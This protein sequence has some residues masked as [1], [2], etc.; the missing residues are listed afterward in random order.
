M[1]RT[2]STVTAIAVALVLAAGFAIWQSLPVVIFGDS[3]M[4]SMT[5]KQIGLPIINQ[6]VGLLITQQISHVVRNFKQA[7][8]FSL[9]RGVILEGGVND[10]ILN[11]D[12]KSIFGSY[13]EMFA[14]IPNGVPITLIGI[15]HI[16]DAATRR[17]GITNEQIDRVDTALTQYCVS[18]PKCRVVKPWDIAPPE[19]VTDGLH[20]TEA[21]MNAVGQ[22][23]RPN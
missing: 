18:R 11:G 5:E 13:V 21:G 8:S 14:A 10:L 6:S 15:V 16:N 1:T 7:R 22:A 20:L 17:F 2:V 3:V 4:A 9:T 12:E 19:F 23:V